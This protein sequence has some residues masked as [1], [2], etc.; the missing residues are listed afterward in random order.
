VSSSFKTIEPA[1]CRTFD[2]TGG[3]PKGVLGA[4]SGAFV[5]RERIVRKAT[6]IALSGGYPQKLFGRMLCG[7][8]ALA[9][10]II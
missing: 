4:S 9:D 1:N 6:S 2:G 5:D 3:L 7:R 10:V 8:P